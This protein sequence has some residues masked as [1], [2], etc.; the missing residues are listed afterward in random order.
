MLI[1]TLYYCIII[2]LYFPQLQGNNDTLDC[3]CL[4][5]TDPPFLCPPPTDGPLC[6]SCAPG[7]YLSP[8]TAEC[9]SCDCHVGGVTAATTCDPSTGQCVCR[10][11]V[12]GLRCDVCPPGYIG[13]SEYTYTPCVKCFC[14]GFSSRGCG[15]DG[16][17]YQARVGNEFSAPGELEGFTSPGELAYSEE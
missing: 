6:R 17:W 11:G 10:A 15:S 9:V 4:P 5:S 8:D 13:P 16:G 7:Y 12:G 1:R 3:P 2:E 14:N